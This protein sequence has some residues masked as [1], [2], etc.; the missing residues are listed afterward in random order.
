MESFLNSVLDAYP[1][2][3]AHPEKVSFVLP[4]KRAGF[5]LRHA[6]A[7]KAGKALLAPEIWSIESLVSHIAGMRYV[8]PLHA[9]FHL[10]EAYLDTPGGEK[11]SFYDFAKWAPTLLQDFNETDRYLVDAEALFEHLAA[12]KE[13]RNWLPDGETTDM[14]ERRTAFWKSL[15]DIY[16]RF[17]ESLAETGMG[18]QGQVY[19]KALETLPEFLRDHPHHYVFLGFNALNTAENRLIQQILEQGMG[20]VYWDADSHYLEDPVHDAGHFMRRYQK[21][22]PALAGELKGSGSYLSQEKKI[23][24]IGLPKAVAQA[25]YCGK[26]LTDIQRQDPGRLNRTAVVLGDETLLGP[27]L[28]SIPEEIPSVNI[29]MGYPIKNSPLAQLFRQLFELWSTVNERGWSIHP[30]L[31]LLSNPFLRKWFAACG[32]QPGQARA[33][34]LEENIFRTS[35]AKLE[36]MGVPTSVS[37]VLFGLEHPSPMDCIKASRRLILALK[38]VYQKDSDREGLEYLRHFFTLF[39]QLEGL[40]SK[41]PYIGSLQALQLLFEQIL[42]D[43]QVDFQGEPLDG[44]QIMG[45][46]ES[47]NLDFETVILTHVNEG[48]LPSGKAHGSFIPFEVKKTFGLPTYKE[49]DAVYTY[50]FYRLLQRA[51]EVYI[52][53]NTEPDVLEGGEPS[54]FIEQLRTDPVLSRYVQETTGVPEL[55]TPPAEPLQIPKDQGLMARLA[56]MGESGFSPTSLS[57]FILDPLEFYKRNVLRISESEILEEHLAA[58]TFGNVLHQALEALFLPWKSKVLDVP[59]VEEMLRKAPGY[60]EAALSDQLLKGAAAQGKNLIALKVLQQQA[61]QFLKQELHLVKHHEVRVLDVEAELKKPLLIPALGKEVY[62]KGTIDRIES[63][64]GEVRIIDYKSGAVSPADLRTCNMEEV[65]SDPK[66]SK[67]FQLLCY[68]WLYS[69]DNP[70]FPYRAGIVSFRNL[71]LGRQWFGVRAGGKKPDEALGPEQVKAFEEVLQNLIAEI[72]SPELILATPE[73]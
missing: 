21:E 67:A 61:N 4:S 8:P 22:W 1:D 14:I 66:R 11:E 37:E 35:T 27:L 58:N 26:I 15:Q 41:H 42:S 33:R 39:N 60:L 69:R 56:E 7:Q 72:Y 20:S 68:A 6:M 53:Y 36:D 38:V 40:C 64:D 62:L 70:V 9:V 63:V 45:M 59:A 31:E 48:I 25:R 12:L 49:K 55:A 16:Y 57:R 30:V 44:L 54:R 28:H 71:S 65:V 73:P 3:K 23:R 17:R 18:Y 34:A 24:L 50:H 19:R 2:W 5:F 51:K 47:R 10:Y 43:Q 29:T 32:F 13:L 46:L 52:C